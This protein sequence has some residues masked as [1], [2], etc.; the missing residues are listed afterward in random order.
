MARTS[1]LL[2][3][4]HLSTSLSND[5]QSHF[6]SLLN[7]CWAQGP[8]GSCLREKAGR[9]PGHF[10]TTQ[11]HTE[12]TT[13]HPLTHA[14]RQHTP[15]F[16]VWKEAG[17]KLYTEMEPTTLLSDCSANHCTLVSPPVVLN[18][19]SPI[20]S[21]HLLL[22]RPPLC[23]TLEPIVAHQPESFTR[24]LTHPSWDEV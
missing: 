8:G 23:Q 22:L 14:D 3:K 2:P 16:G 5:I 7:T 21:I 11:G 9:R 4:L 19:F 15:T 17:C 24:K 18:M 1:C 13:I 6:P 20:K 10:I 12:T